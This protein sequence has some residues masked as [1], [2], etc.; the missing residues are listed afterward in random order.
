[1]DC[2]IQIQR[3]VFILFY[4]KCVKYIQDYH[5]YFSND[6]ELNVGN[7]SLPYF[8]ELQ[9]KISRQVC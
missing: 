4:I 5:S 9:E 8:E 3:Y 6:K 2:M 7:N 1:M